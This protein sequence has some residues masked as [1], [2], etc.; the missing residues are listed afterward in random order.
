MRGGG[1]Y[2]LDPRHLE[3][4]IRGLG[5]TARRRSG[6]HTATRPLH[7]PRPPAEV[8]GKSW[9]LKEAVAL[10]ANRAIVEY[11]PSVPRPQVG[12]FDQATGG[13]V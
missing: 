7:A 12:E 4:A 10:V 1:H 6:R 9:R 11:S 3:P 8:L 2:A 13:G 5:T